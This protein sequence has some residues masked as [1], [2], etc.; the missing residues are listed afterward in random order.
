MKLVTSSII[1]TVLVSITIL[2]ANC[3]HL[4][5][6]QGSFPQIQK[7]TAGT[8]WLDVRVDN[9]TVRVLSFNE[10]HLRIAIES[11]NHD[12]VCEPGLPPIITAVAP[13]AKILMDSYDKKNAKLLTINLSLTQNP[14]LIKKWAGFL[15]T[16][17]RWKNRPKQKNAW[18]TSE[19]KLILSLLEEGDI[20]S[21]YKPLFDQFAYLKDKKLRIEKVDYQNVS[22]LSFYESDLRALNYA[23]HERLPIPLMVDVTL[24]SL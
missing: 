8:R 2:I 15:K 21:S 20:F 14:T 9:C 16:S 24:K 13:A 7:D 1:K 22:A 12:N 18:D 6:P 19:Y 10:F 11:P 4:F 23:P 5:S 17:D 3:N